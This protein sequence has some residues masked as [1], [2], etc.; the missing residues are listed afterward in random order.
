[1]LRVHWNFPTLAAISLFL[2]EFNILFEYPQPP[3]LST[4][5]SLI[6]YSKIFWRWFIKMFT[7][8]CWETS[9]FYH[10]EAKFKGWVLLQISFF[11]FEFNTW[12]KT[13]Y[14]K[15]WFKHLLFN[16]HSCWSKARKKWYMWVLI[17]QAKVVGIWTRLTLCAGNYFFCNFSV[18]RISDRNLEG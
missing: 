9:R 13:E 4:Q 5:S 12:S 11:V 14:A 16:I 7:A 2:S 17:R 8:F 1:M 3:R 18:N 15:K 10:F 6:S